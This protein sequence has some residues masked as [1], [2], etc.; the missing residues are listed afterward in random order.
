MLLFKKKEKKEMC[1]YYLFLGRGQIL[2][3]TA[4]ALHN[5][6]KYFSLFVLNLLSS[7][8]SVLILCDRQLSDFLPTLFLNLNHPNKSPLTPLQS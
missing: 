8:F 4:L 7:N 3:T 2:S 5:T 1:S 6:K